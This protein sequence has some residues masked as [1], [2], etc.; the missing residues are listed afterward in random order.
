MSDKKMETQVETGSKDT[1]F[2]AVKTRSRKRKLTQ[3]SGASDVKPTEMDTADQPTE[4]KRPHFPP[5]SGDKLKVFQLNL[6]PYDCQMFVS[7]CHLFSLNIL[8]LSPITLK[9]LRNHSV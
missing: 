6:C 1:E 9:C 7:C 8:L 2:V 4:I 5:I 3:D